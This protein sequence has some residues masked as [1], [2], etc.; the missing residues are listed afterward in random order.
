M[1]SAILFLM[2]TL[3]FAAEAERHKRW[4]WKTC[5][6]DVDCG[7]DRCCI[8]VLKICAP[9]REE[10]ESC[11]FSHLHGCDCKDGLTCQP[12]GSLIT[13]YKCMPEPGSGGGAL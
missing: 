12:Y 13:L 1:K 8:S 2:L 3:V 6:T 4:L 9:K 5:S 11:N 10:G 7:V